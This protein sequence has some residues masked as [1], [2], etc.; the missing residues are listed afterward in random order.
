MKNTI[1]GLSY[2]LVSGITI[3]VPSASHAQN[4][5][6]AQEVLSCYRP[7]A[8]YLGGYV[9]D[10]SSRDSNTGTRYHSG[11]VRYKYSLLDNTTHTMSI[12]VLVR[13]D[14]AYQVRINRDTSPFPVSSECYLSGWTY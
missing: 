11:E 8:S 9:S 13:N 2:F 3:L 10:N 4:A 5:S 1:L 12:T 7:W 6:I 14:G